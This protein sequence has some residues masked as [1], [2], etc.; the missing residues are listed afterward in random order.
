MIKGDVPFVGKTLKGKIVHTTKAGMLSEHFGYFQEA[1]FVDRQVYQ[2]THLKT[3][4]RIVSV[5]NKRAADAIIA[6]LEAITPPIPW[7]EMNDKNAN[8][9]R[10]A[11]SGILQKYAKAL[12]S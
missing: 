4:R 8:E 10:A 9:N 11:V 12:S 6:D 7:N 5:K 3:G 2:V 1:L